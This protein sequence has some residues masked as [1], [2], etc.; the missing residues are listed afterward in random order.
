MPLDPRSHLQKIRIEAVERLQDVHGPLQRVR[1]RVGDGRVR[2]LAFHRHFQLQT[3]VL[4]RHH[5]V[6]K[7]RRE[8]Q[9]GLRQA[10]RQQPAQAR[11]A[12][13]FFVAGAVQ[14]YR[15]APRTGRRLQR[16]HSKG[17][18]GKVAFAHRGRAPV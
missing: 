8:Q 15:A 3:A 6:G 14:L 2:H 16:A 13:H 5:L 12:A 10:L 4:R 18:G 7:A 11:F 1:A 17:V 9:V